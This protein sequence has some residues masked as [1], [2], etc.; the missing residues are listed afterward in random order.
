MKYKNISIKGYRGIKELEL[1][2]LGNVNLILGQNNVGKSSILK[3][4]FY[5]QVFEIRKIR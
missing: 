5:L 1:N 3:L 4:F 2:G